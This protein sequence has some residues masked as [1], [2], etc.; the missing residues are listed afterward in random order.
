[1]VSDPD[2]ARASFGQDWAAFAQYLDFVVTMNYGWVGQD[3]GLTR[4]QAASLKGK[5]LFFPAIGGMPEQHEQF[6]P[7]DWIA[8]VALARSAGAE[9]IAIYAIGYLKPETCSVLAA[10]PFKTPAAIPVK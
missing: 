9:G 10:G 2:Y 8:M 6:T 5:A 3:E 1:V 4:R 7:D